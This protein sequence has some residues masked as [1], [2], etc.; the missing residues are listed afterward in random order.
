MDEG[1]MRCKH[2]D[3]GCRFRRVR[4][5]AIDQRSVPA[6]PASHAVASQVSMP[7][8]DPRDPPH[9]LSL[10]LKGA[11]PKGVSPALL[12]QAAAARYQ[13]GICGPRDFGNIFSNRNGD[14]LVLY[15]NSAFAV[16]PAILDLIQPC[17]SMQ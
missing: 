12:V 2:G 5:D 6:E 4:V 8:T 13:N 7:L 10:I 16:G 11:L 14:K 9:V 17:L 3:D 15:I 1:R